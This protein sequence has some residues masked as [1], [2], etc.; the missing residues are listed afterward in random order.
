MIMKIVFALLLIMLICATS[1]AA[2]DF[3][4]S[5]V[6][7]A[8]VL[9]FQFARID[10]PGFNLRFRRLNLACFRV[11]CRSRKPGELLVLDGGVRTEI[12]TLVE[13]A[14]QVFQDEKQSVG[15]GLTSLIVNNE[16]DLGFCLTFERTIEK[17]AFIRAEF[18][19]NRKIKAVGLVFGF[20][21]IDVVRRF[22]QEFLTIRQHP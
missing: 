11:F 8:P 10:G 19:T 17:L 5:P 12:G 13:L 7:T 15:I 4:I 16:K 21:L 20:D 18:R 22:R 14:Y 3:V 9:S 1:S 2:K 6:T